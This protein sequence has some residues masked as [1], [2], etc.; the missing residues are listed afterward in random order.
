MWAIGP[1]FEPQYSVSRILVAKFIEI[2]TLIDDTYDGYATIDE[3][4][5]FTAAIE[6]LVNYFRG[7]I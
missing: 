6:R 4:Q 7:F 1:H 2:L 3:V 5:H